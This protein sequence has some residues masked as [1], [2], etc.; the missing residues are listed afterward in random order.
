MTKVSQKI[1]RVGAMVT[2]LATIAAPHTL[3]NERVAQTVT[4]DRDSEEKTGESP[5]VR[6]ST[7]GAE[8][9]RKNVVLD[10]TTEASALQ[11]VDSHLPELRPILE[12]LRRVQPKAYRKAVIGLARSSRRL[13]A[14]RQRDEP[15]FDVEL[16]ELKLRT[17]VDLLTA[18]L[19]VRDSDKDRSELQTAVTNLQSVQVQRLQ[20]EVEFLKQRVANAKQTL[21][22][23]QERLKSKQSDASK[24]IEKAIEASLRKAGRLDAGRKR[25]SKETVAND[26]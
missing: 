13:E 6:K 18:K 2:V 11:L 20:L 4:A 15:T 21:E 17:Q 25:N 10:A 19:K 3:A 22:T 8:A 5:T 26:E 12:N 14:L 9:S 16:Q 7:S 23:A 24:Q 1:I